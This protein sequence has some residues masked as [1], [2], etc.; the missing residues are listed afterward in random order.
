MLLRE[1]LDDYL[2]KP[3]TREKLEYILEKY[4]KVEQK[5]LSV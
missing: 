1:G 4:L 3:L 5:P 2:A